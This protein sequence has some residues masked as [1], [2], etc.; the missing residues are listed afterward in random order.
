[1]TIE[2]NCPNSHRLRLSEQYAGKRVRCPKCQAVTE[3]PAAVASAQPLD[4]GDARRREEELEQEKD[5]R[6]A[7][8]KRD[9]RW[10]LNLVR[11]GITLQLVHFLLLLLTILI[12]FVFAFI[13][14]RSGEPATFLLFA[15][16]V[17]GMFIL[18]E[19]IGIVG[20]VLCLMVPKKAGAST[21]ML[22]SLGLHI[23]DL[24]LSGATFF[25]PKEEIVSGVVELLGDILQMGSWLTFMFYLNR[26]AIYLKTRY[27]EDDTEAVMRL[28]VMLWL[29]RIILTI[30]GFVLKF[31]FCIGALLSLGLAIGLLV[32]AIMFLIKYVA[33][34]FNFRHELG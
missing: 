3:V 26:L 31:L 13:A 15:A 27:L 11:V 4:D 29:T 17:G 30:G 25:L 9:R 21:V 28:G 14:M 22:M 20:S 8:R 6:R 23:A 32:L 33:L 1:M 12:G 24:A 7:E 2:V 18:N 16:I 10:R 5:E 19:L 34:L